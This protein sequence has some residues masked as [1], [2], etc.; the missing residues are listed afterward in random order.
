MAGGSGAFRADEWT[1]EQV[2]GDEMG[3]ASVTTLAITGATGF[4]GGALVERALSAGHG[5]RALTRRP[6]RARDGVTWVEGRLIG[7]TALPHW[8]M[9]PTRSCMSRAS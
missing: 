8:S 1:P 7:P 3:E 9:E 6:Q 4:V 5:V 2:R